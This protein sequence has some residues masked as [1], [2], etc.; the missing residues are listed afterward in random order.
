MYREVE[1][2]QMYR[3]VERY[4]DVWRG[5]EVYRCIERQII[6]QDYRI[7]H[8]VL[9]QHQINID[10][11]DSYNGFQCQVNLTNDIEILTEI[12]GGGRGEG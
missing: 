2:I 11:I 4:I 9:N 5:R 3:E 6:L 1:R 10:Y 8:E 7:L 12:Q